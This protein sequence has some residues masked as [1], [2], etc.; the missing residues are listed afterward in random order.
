M[1]YGAPLLASLAV[2]L[3]AGCGGGPGAPAKK[4]PEQQYGFPAADRPV[5]TIVS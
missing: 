5:A 4:Q 1:R 2:L 3:L